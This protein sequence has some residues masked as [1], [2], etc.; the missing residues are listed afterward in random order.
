MAKDP[1]KDESLCR[2]PVGTVTSDQRVASTVQVMGTNPDVVEMAPYRFGSGC[3]PHCARTSTVGRAE[4]QGGPECGAL[5][6]ALE[7]QI[8]D[9]PAPR[10][11]EQVEDTVC[12]VFPQEK[13]Q[14]RF[15]EPEVGEMVSHDRI[16][17]RTAE[18]FQLLSCR[19]EFLTGSVKRAGLSK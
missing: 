4:R 3:W 2:N 8:L 6:P 18:Q 9:V 19:S 10:A 17:R 12:E 11:A 13:V 1:G 7:E 5:W 16:Q 14:Q 15:V